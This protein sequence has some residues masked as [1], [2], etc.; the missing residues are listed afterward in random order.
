MDAEAE[1][2]DQKVP[3]GGVWSD[4]VS[5]S[6]A[7]PSTKAAIVRCERHTLYGQTRAGQGENLK[8]VQLPQ[9]N[10]GVKDTSVSQ[11][12]RTCR[13]C[14]TFETGHCGTL[15]KARLLSTATG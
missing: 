6:D 3:H 13:V 5:L 2:R 11:V 15:Q 14:L 9:I 10:R 8:H 7:R 12:N 1:E 4:S